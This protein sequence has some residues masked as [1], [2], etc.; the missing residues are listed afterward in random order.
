M[1]TNFHDRRRV[2]RGACAA[3]GGALLPLVPMAPVSAQVQAAA[4]PRFAITDTDFTLDG[5]RIQI[6]CGEMHFARVPREYWGHRLKAIKAMGLNTVCA[7]LFWNYHE[8]REGRYDWAGQ[9]DAVEFCRLAQQEGL[10]V[11]LRP[12]P[13]ACAEW[14]MGGLPWWLLKHPGD[15]F[16]RTRDEGYMAPAR[17]WM[18]EVGR[19]LGRQQITHGGPILMVQVEN[20]YGFFGEDLDYMRAMRQVLL[21]GGFDVPLFQCNPTNAVVKTHIKE[22]FSVA[23]FGSDP[24][25]GFKALDQVQKGPRMC[26][27][28]YS[29]W[30]DTWGSPHKR[31]SNASA[32]ADIAAMLKANGS[33]SLYMAHGGTTFGLWGGCDRPFRPDTSSYDYDA[34]ISEAGWMGEKFQAYRDGMKPYLLPGETLPPPPAHNPVIAIAPFSFRQSASVF[35]SLPA[36]VIKAVSPQ[37]I[38]HYDISRGIVSY[39]ITLPAG[40]AAVL[41]A[42]KVRDLAWVYVDGKLAGTLDTR[43]RRFKVD[44]PARSK[45]VTLEILL[46]TIARVNFGVEIHDRK[47]MHGPVTLGGQPLENWEIRA[48]DFDADAVLPPLAWK[49]GRTAGP[50]FWRASFDVAD[51]GDTFLDMS[52]WGQGIVWVNGRCL[53]R[54]WSIGPTQ[55]MYLPGP[56]IRRGA[57]EVVVLDLTGPQNARSAGLKTPILDRLQPDR[58]LPRPPNT[59][60]TQL[61]GVKPVHEGEFQRGAAT[62]DVTFAQPA[63]GRQFCLESLDA[64]DGKQ[65]AA[66]A[67][68]ALLGPD[69]KTL[70]Q[71]NWTIAFVDSEEASK[72]DGGALNAI[73]G[74][75]TDHWHTAYSGKSASAHPHRIV[76]DLGK[77]DTVAGMRYTPRQGPEGVTGRIRRYRVYVADRLVVER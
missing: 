13:Y 68:L 70:N 38:E 31:G 63:T 4:S 9:R 28:Y 75:N 24:A 51:T 7:Y 39:R 26:G 49:T 61:D 74:Q 73:N 27:E 71:S 64:F 19:V 20:E 50:A 1:T 62:Q 60:R 25:A 46:Y 55:T 44:L 33:F 76:I 72:E 47:G 22:L 12:G 42:A 41:E 56:W 2:L 66:I 77:T 48:I 52:T 58:D 14:E 34:P 10:W 21:D 67:E 6:R 40:P 29:G 65:F 53:G 30:F 23:N 57:N 18:K 35:A 17:R 69:G 3:V 5:K 11:I 8:W 32:V 16:L 36:K 45:S 59:A 54:Y 43:Y 37:P 15:S